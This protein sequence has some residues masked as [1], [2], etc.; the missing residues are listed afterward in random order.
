[1]RCDQCGTESSGD[2]CPSCGAPMGDPG[3][4]ACPACGA[5]ADPDAFFCTECGEPLRERPSKGLRAYLPWI[6]SGL[7][8]AAFAVGITVLV[9]D[10]AAPRRAGS[11]PTGG[12]IEGGGD[13]AA[14]MGG[15]AATGG[16]PS[17]TDLS[18]MSPR[19]AADRLFNRTMRMKEGGAPA[20]SVRFFA[21]MGVRAYSQVP[22]GQ[23]GAD[24]RFH[25]G[26]LELARDEPRA[27]MARA[28]SILAGEEGNL[29]GLLLA[30]RA[31]E[32]AGDADAAERYRSRLRARVEEVDLDGRPSYRAHRALLEEYAAGG[33]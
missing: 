12:V 15:G 29:L 14:G 4:R 10:Q 32:A 18:S 5:G 8:L 6:L 25:V 3:E 27:A 21:R 22:A 19:E 13:G 24:L 2:Y 30:A 28:D 1:M 33:G 16:M 31:A 23:A 9:Q 20:D 26:L 17:A 11:P 7:A